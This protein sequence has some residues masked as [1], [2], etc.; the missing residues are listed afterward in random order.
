MNKISIYAAEGRDGLFYAIINAPTS[1]FFGAG[2]K[3]LEAAADEARR[4]HS[5]L[6]GSLGNRV[7]HVVRQAGYEYPR[8]LDLPG[9]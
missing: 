8:G 7:L 4:L 5:R 9:P 3:T 6:I 1:H 2:L